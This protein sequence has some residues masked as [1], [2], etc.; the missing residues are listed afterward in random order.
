ML[1]IYSALPLQQNLGAILRSAHFLGAAG[2]LCCKRNSAPL[3]PV[4]A[5]ASAG[6]L[7]AMALHSCSSMPRTLASAAANG[8]LVLGEPCLH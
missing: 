4:V 5:K 6:A 7:D 1:D 8:W 2:V 3:S